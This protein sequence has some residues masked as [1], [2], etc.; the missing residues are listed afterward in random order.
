MAMPGN[1]IQ[2]EKETSSKIHGTGEL[3][4]TRNVY[5]QENEWS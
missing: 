3:S 4:N 1:P 2:E 5:F